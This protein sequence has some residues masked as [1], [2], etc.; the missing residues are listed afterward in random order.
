MA[1]A[2]QDVAL[3]AGTQGYTLTGRPTRIRAARL[4]YPN[5]NP[6][7]YPVQLLSVLDYEYWDARRYYDVGRTR[8]DTIVYQPSLPS[9]QLTVAPIP[10][11]ACTLRVWYDSAQPQVTGVSD[12]LTLSAAYYKGLMLQ[13]AMELAPSFSA[14]I[15]PVTQA[16]WQDAIRTIKALNTVSQGTPYDSRAPGANGRFDIT[17]G[18]TYGS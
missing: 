5:S 17:S 10:D 18:L 16:A 1:L 12:T 2:F 9:N 14:A 7:L 15:S 13:L 4:S 3:L 11:Q 8:P 6:L